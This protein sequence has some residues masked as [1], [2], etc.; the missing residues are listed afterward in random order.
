MNDLIRILDKI[1]FFFVGHPKNI[2]SE[3]SQELQ[4]NLNLDMTKS[5]ESE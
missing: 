3:V 4:D 5:V 1:Y 2:F